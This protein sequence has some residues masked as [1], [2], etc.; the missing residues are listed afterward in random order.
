MERNLATA[1][2]RVTPAYVRYLEAR[3]AGGAAVVFTESSYVRA[4]GKARHHQMGIHDD[5]AVPRLRE[6]AERIHRHGSLLGVELNH[7]GRTAQTAVNGVGC[8]APSPVPCAV[9]GGE[10][11]EIL[12]EVDIR[13]LI[14]CF[15]DAAL[16]CQEAGVDVI[17]L[18]GAHGYLI[19]QFMSPRTN[20]RDDEWA[21]PAK[22]LTEVIEAV[23]AAVPTAT[24]GIRF[25]ALEGPIDGLSAE[26]TLEIVAQAPLDRLDFLDISAG[27]YEAGEWIVQPGEWEEGVL[28][29]FARRYRQFGLPVSVVGRITEPE[30]AERLLQRGDA[31]LV[32]VGRALHADPAWAAAA[33]G[34]QR[35][36]PCIATNHC[37]DS[38]FTGQP[39]PCSVNADVAAPIAELG[40]D[41]EGNVIVVVGAGPGGLESAR[42]SAVRGARVVLFERENALGGQVR[43]SARLRTYPR[44]QT[45]ID[46]YDAELR[47]LSVELRLGEKASPETVAALSPHAVMVATGGRGVVPDIPGIWSSRVHEI[48]AWLWAGAPDL[49]D[50]QH[51]VWGADRE[52]VAV[53]DDL[54]ARGK[55]V[56]VIGDQE[57]LAPDVGRRAKILTVPRLLSDP[58]ADIRLQSRVLAVTD[59]G[60]TVRRQRQETTVPAP[61]PILV[62][63]GVTPVT[64]LATALRHAGYRSPVYLVGDAGDDGGSIGNAIDT[65]AR[66]VRGLR[67]ARSRRWPH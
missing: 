66:A 30:T 23:R 24:L 27:S 21:A 17:M 34:G 20:L 47:D 44:Y 55:R 49:G 40:A 8:V 4:D 67:T 12:D 7:G 18:H 43:L 16:R 54:L 37:I 14:R 32:S 57:S 36:R 53:A 50:E 10:I 15:G 1:S 62:S 9:A 59:G 31:D 28:G 46:W 45:I 52:G 33:A 58:H 3:A 63:Q 13:D 2:G 25:S 11:P 29:R 6:L 56:L 35:F 19:H 22:F 39:V 60:L 48:R 65:A 41:L 61:G 42:A 51:V 26:G 64:D 5:S 38:L